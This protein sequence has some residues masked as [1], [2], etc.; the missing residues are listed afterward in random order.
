MPSVPVSMAYVLVSGFRRL[1]LHATELAQV[2]MAT[3]HIQLFKIGAQVL[4]P[5]YWT[6][7]EIHGNTLEP[8]SG[9]SAKRA[10]TI[11]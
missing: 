8:P 1:G 11:V 3:I 10:K 9:Q 4:N 6:P 5:Q 2:Q 7:P